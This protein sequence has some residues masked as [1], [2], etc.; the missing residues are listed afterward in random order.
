MRAVTIHSL[1]DFDNEYKTKIDFSKQT[2]N[3]ADLLSLEV[4]LL[5]EVSMIDDACFTGICDTLSIVDHT[6]RPAARPSDCFGPMHII[7]FGDFKQLPP[8]SSRAPFIVLP[9]VVREFDFRCLRENRRVIQDASRRGE[10]DLFHKVLTDISHSDYSNDV[11]DF[12]V[13]AYVRGYEIGCA[14]NVPFEGCTAVFAK[15]RYRDKW[16]RT[17]VRRVAKKHNHSIKIKGKVRSRGVRSQQWYSDQRVAY[18]R[19][20]CRTQNLWNLHLAGDWHQSIETVQQRN[21]KPHL[22]RVMMV[23]N[24]AG[25]FCCSNHEM[26]DAIRGVRNLRNRIRVFYSVVRWWVGIQPRKGRGNF[27]E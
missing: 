22:M 7:L 15:R 11:K 26:F 27:H 21:P 18:L 13:G 20:K 12:K 6:R 19:K 17:V 9:R 5:D 23:A 4:L 16:N 14:E 25:F 1:F 24:I 8:A 2:Q 10:L 3:V